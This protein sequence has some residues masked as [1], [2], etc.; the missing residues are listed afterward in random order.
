MD[1]EGIK[2]A[3][4]SEKYSFLREDE[5]LKKSICLLAVGGSHAYGTSEE[6]SDVDIRGCAFSSRRDILTGR[7]F[8]QFIDHATDTVIYSFP[9]CIHLLSE[10]NPSMVEMLGC[11]DEDY[12]VLDDT[13]RR[14]IRESGLFLSR[15]AINTYGGYA[16]AQLYHLMQK[17]RGKASGEEQ[18][19]HVRDALENASRSFLNGHLSGPGSS[20]RFSQGEEREGEK[21]EKDER[22]IYVDVTLRH[23]P[24]RECAGLTA[25][26]R[27]VLK[28]CKQTDN[29]VPEERNRSRI[30]KH[31]MHLIRL[32]A[33]GTDI[34]ANG[35]IITYRSREHSLLM[36]IRRGLYLDSDNRPTKA[37]DEVL[38]EFRSHF[39]EACRD[40]RLPDEPDR[41]RI[42]R[43]LMEVNSAIV[44]QKEMEPGIPENRL[45]AGRGDFEH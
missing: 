20:V 25:G 32:Y 9:K 33:T 16:S 26:L 2:E 3:V 10:C 42:D 45:K 35:E 30:A 17:S 8:G 43:L 14:L 31:M 44:T 22:E 7:D 21:E 11:M 19:Q 15:K 5:R 13:G 6:G 34:L 24:I 27:E 1:I 39:N 36:D 40:T 18:T 28:S 4:K 38:D 23:L 12:L 29:A 37:F 41:E